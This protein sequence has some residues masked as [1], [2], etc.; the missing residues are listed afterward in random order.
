[1]NDASRMQKAVDKELT[2]VFRAVPAP[3][4][5]QDFEARLSARLRDAAMAAAAQSGAPRGRIPGRRWIMR[6]Y[7]AVAALAA[8]LA[9]GQA[10]LQ[11][12]QAQT[13][14]LVAIVMAFVMQRVMHPWSLRR[15]IRLSMR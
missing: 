4:P 13:L 15:V 14:A 6:V 12:A 5:S 3:R 10:M 8:T 11:P 9:G 1:M 2:R 7:W